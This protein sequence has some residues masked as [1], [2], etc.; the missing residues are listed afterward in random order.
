ML[1]PDEILGAIESESAAAAATITLIPLDARVASCPDWSFAELIWHLARVQRFWATTVRAGGADP[2]E[3]ARAAVPSDAG[4]LETFFREST[5]QLV[6]A[7]HETSWEAPAWTWWKDERTV[8]AIARHQVQ[9]AAVHRWD[10]Q[11]ALRSPDPLAPAVAEDGVDEFLWI[12][13]QL[14]GLEPIAFHA[15]DAGST[16]AAGP[17]DP[18]ATVSA[19]ASD[20]VLLLYGR[21]TVDDVEVTGDRAALDAYLVPI[22]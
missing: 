14:R 22:S 20:L 16:F 13:R 18:I 11:S 19:P 15:T 7:L 5:R 1:T 4:E 8:G 6:D 17:G 12:A 10:A 21:L 9:E 3:P 2:V